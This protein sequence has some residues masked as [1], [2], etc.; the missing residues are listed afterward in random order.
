MI[1]DKISVETQLEMAMNE[2]LK[3]WTFGTEMLFL[4]VVPNNEFAEEFLI[5][6]NGRFF[7]GVYKDSGWSYSSYNP[8]PYTI[9]NPGVPSDFRVKTFVEVLEMSD[10]PPTVDFGYTGDMFVCYRVVKDEE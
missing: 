5:N 7:V 10:E 6:V 9:G 3:D 1:L 4:E 8:F 2:K